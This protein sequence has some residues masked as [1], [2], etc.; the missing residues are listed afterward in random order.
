MLGVPP[1]ILPDVVAADLELEERKEKGVVA[2]TIDFGSK[3]A[4]VDTVAVV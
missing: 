1:K 4:F 3:V 2:A